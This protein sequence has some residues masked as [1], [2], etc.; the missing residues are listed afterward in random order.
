MQWEHHIDV[1]QIEEELVL[2]T[3]FLDSLLHEGNDWAFII[4]LHAVLETSISVLLAS[5]VR[6]MG[7]HEIANEAGLQDLASTSPSRLDEIFNR[8]PLGDI[9]T[10]K[11]AFCTAMDLIDK[12]GSRF[13]REIS[14][15]RNSLVHDIR[16]LSFSLEQYV[17]RLE[18]SA[19][20]TFLRDLKY[21]CEDVVVIYDDTG[22]ES[23]VDD[24]LRKHPRL[25]IWL[26]FLNAL[27]NIS[28][29]IMARKTMSKLA[30]LKAEEAYLQ[31]KAE[32]ILDEMR[33]DLPNKSIEEIAALKREY[34]GTA[35]ETEFM[36]LLDELGIQI[37]DIH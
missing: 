8:L 28:F 6:P 1:R 29:P 17:A 31:D 25:W 7:L 30:I 4:K 5:Q 11:L 34:A 19:F 37:Q 3:G 9:K 12:N 10:G 16:N 18:S 24:G 2:P 13:I 36:K 33:K 35:A 15:I 20:K 22:E 21:Y 26:S 27:H 32:A 14:R 23:R